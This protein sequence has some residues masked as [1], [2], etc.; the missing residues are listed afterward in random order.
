MIYFSLCLQFVE[1]AEGMAGPQTGHALKAYLRGK[2]G[3][4]RGES[5]DLPLSLLGR[6]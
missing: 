3:G 5:N 1:E 4:E 2:G 6:T